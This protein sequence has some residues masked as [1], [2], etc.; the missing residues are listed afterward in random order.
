MADDT[1]IATRHGLYNLTD[2]ASQYGVG[3]FNA[4]IQASGPKWIGIGSTDVVPGKEWTRVY[5]HAQAVQDFGAGEYEMTLH[6][7][8]QVQ[9]LEI[10]G[11]AMLN[12]GPNVDVS[13]LPCTPIRYAGQDPDAPWRAAAAARIENYRK[14]DLRVRVVDT[15]T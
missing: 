11:I 12:L 9:T 10:G 14:G 3:G 8:S 13:K 15:R 6:L 7:G 1:L 5:I 4:I 2:L